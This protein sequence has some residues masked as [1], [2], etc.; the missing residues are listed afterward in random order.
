MLHERALPHVRTALQALISNKDHRVFALTGA[1]GTGKTFLWKEIERELISAGSEDLSPVYISLFGVQKIKDLRLRLLKQVTSKDK[2]KVQKVLS[3]LSWATAGLAQRF[4]GIS[5][6]DIVL[7][8]LPDMLKGRLVVIDDVERKS[9]ALGIDEFLGFID[10]H[11]VSHD[12]R[13]LLLLN[14]D[15]LGESAELWAKLR[16]KV[17]DAELVL[18]TTPREAF[19]IALGTRDYKAGHVQAARAA[20]QTLSITNIRVIKRVLNIV[21]RIFED[22]GRPDDVA[23]E[24][25]VPSTVLMAAAHYRALEDP[26]TFEYLRGENSWERLFRAERDGQTPQHQRWNQLLST[27]QIRSADQFEDILEAF[28]KT[29][30]MD[31]TELRSL[32]QQYRDTQGDAGADERRKKFLCDF[33][34]EADVSINA[35][36]EA[37]RALLPDAPAM[38]PPYITEIIEVAQE[39]GDAELAL[40]FLAAWKAAA[41]TRPEYRNLRSRTPSITRKLHPEVERTLRELFDRQNPPLSLREAVEHLVSESGWNDRHIVPLEKSTPAEYEVLIQSVSGDGLAKI[42]IGHLEWITQ[43]A[44]DP[45]FSHATRNFVAAAR[46][47]CNSVP[48][49]RIATILRRSFELKGMEDRL[50]PD[51]ESAIATG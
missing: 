10:E 20:L 51:A 43:R 44:N 28:L 5:V 3:A 1:W 24:R 45:R 18:N 17:I 9:S 31:G 4:G 7:T 14:E 29:G 25:W 2:S 39:L 34:W 23:Y 50:Q 6:E 38:A 41:E 22:S 42:V 48:Q 11:A 40:S 26:P 21:N 8:W 16:E 27:L 49:S 13:V 15:R 30:L 37:A 32:F 33:Y 36:I 35:L 19:E 12:V 47:I 46:S